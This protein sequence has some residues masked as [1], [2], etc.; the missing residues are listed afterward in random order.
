VLIRGC[1]DLV[2]SPPVVDQVASQESREIDVNVG[3]F[4]GSD[5]IDKSAGL[6]PTTL[7]INKLD[8]VRVGLVRLVNRVLPV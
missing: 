4:D 7:P 2:F 6:L 8:V 1:S 3:L 5:A